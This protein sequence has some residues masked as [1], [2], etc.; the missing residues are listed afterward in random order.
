MSAFHFRLQ[1]LLGF[2]LVQEEQARRELG[3]RQVQ[4]EQE[5][6]RLNSL[7]HEERE[8]ISR[9]SRELH[10]EIALPRLQATLDYGRVLE[11][12]LNR[13]E[14]SYHRSRD[15]VE[16]QRAVAERCW[17]KKKVLEILENRARAEH[18]RLEKINERNLIDEI[19]LNNYNRKGGD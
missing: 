9:W 4:M 2:R 16:E 11:E 17:R 14:R 19:V 15:L 1:R 12:R 8:I 6:G 7:Q 18:N 10:D 5:K 13:Q 3:L